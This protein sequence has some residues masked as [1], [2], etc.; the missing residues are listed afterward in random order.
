MF[1]IVAGLVYLLAMAVPVY[2]LYRFRTRSWYW[3]VLAILAAFGVGLVHLPEAW[4]SEWLDVA[5]G[6]AFILPLAWGVGGLVVY[7]PHR[8]H[9]ERH[10]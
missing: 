3:H 1:S 9:Q 10:A 7:R 2:L 6:F 8:R 4:H 5:I